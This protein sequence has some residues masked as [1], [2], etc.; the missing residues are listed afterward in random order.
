MRTKGLG[1]EFMELSKYDLL[2]VAVLRLRGR[3]AARRVVDRIDALAPEFTDVFFMFETLECLERGLNEDSPGEHHLVMAYHPDGEKF[4]KL[5]KRIERGALVKNET[6][7]V[8]GLY[9][10]MANCSFRAQ[11]CLFFDRLKVEDA[12]LCKAMNPLSRVFFI[13]RDVLTLK[14]IAMEE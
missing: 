6:V 12:A 1:R 14:G 7:S 11:H 2:T 8:L 3:L 9:V 13:E 5:F 10:K 4:G